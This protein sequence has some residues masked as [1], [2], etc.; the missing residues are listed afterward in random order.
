M[1]I[2]SKLIRARARV[3]RWFIL[4]DSCS[5]YNNQRAKAFLFDLADLVRKIISSYDWLGTND[6]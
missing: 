6:K 1:M 4:K 2:G 3:A 5:L